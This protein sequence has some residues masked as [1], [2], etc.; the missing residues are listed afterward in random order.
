MT[1]E[2]SAKLREFVY[3]RWDVVRE[4]STRFRD[5]REL[6]ERLDDVTPHEAVWFLEALAADGTEPPLCSVG[7]DNKH[8]STRTPP[9]ADGGPRGNVFFEKPGDFAT[10]RLETVIHQAAVWR[11]HAQFG[12]PLSHLVIE[13]P[14]IV[15]DDQ[16]LL[17]RREALDILLLEEPCA[18]LPSR[19]TAST[20]RSRVGVEVKADLAG[21]E[22][23]LNAMRDCQ[24]G[25]IGADDP[26]HQR[27]HKKCHALDVLRPR[28]FLAVAAGE[29]WR[30]LRVIDQNGRA[31]F[32]GELRTL[33][34]LC[35]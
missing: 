1:D 27:D 23:L 7:E 35:F 15:D 20:A 9:N 19:M 21:L 10:L 2:A 24:E 6:R 5:C 25:R 18:A 28:L 34:E 3:E 31:V 32:G 29:T 11:L 12:W 30:L 22:R 33:E 8:R 14:D 26:R 16:A 13:S 17:L 4:S